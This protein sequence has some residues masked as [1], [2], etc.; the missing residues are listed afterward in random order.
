MDSPSYA[1][2]ISPYADDV[3]IEVSP[4]LAPDDTGA[5]SSDTLADLVRF[6]VDAEDG[7]LRHV[8]LVLAGH[9][10][11]RSLNRD[12]LEHDY[13][14]DVLAF[15]FSEPASPPEPADADPPPPPL[16]EGEVYVD[17]ETAAER[18]DEFGASLEEEVCR[19][20]VHGVLHL[21]GYTDKTKDANR[22]MHRLEDRYLAAFPSD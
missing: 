21:L 19:Y 9:E 17:V 8:S 11:V 22:T 18:H 10:T 1:D 2:D 4:S 12:Y 7:R 5:L 20:I 6:V 16:V 15:S 3:H 13:N 14:T